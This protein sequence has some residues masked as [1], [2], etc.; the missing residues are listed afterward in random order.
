MSLDFRTR[1]YFSSMKIYDMVNMLDLRVGLMSSC[2]LKLL[3][4]KC[5]IVP[6]R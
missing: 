4:A 3:E 1:L 2:D 5:N 6:F